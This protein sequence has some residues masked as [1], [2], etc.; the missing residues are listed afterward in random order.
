MR[1][2]VAEARVA[3]CESL[4]IRWGLDAI[5][6]CGEVLHRMAESGDVDE[7]SRLVV[8]RASLDYQCNY[9]AKPDRFMPNALPDTAL[10]RASKNGHAL[11]V[12]TLLAAG[13]E[14]DHLGSINRTAL[15]GAA[16]EGQSLIVDILI[17]A[18]ANLNRLDTVQYTATRLAH[19]GNHSQ[20]E[21]TLLAA[22][23]DWRR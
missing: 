22:G 8:A 10:I 16:Q 19:M 7:V 18:G 17:A 15:M 3:V 21:A 4:C 2:G 6:E 23:A 11:V 12:N 5:E 14:I 9:S 1:E 13:A 20:I